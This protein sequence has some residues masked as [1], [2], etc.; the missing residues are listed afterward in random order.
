MTLMYFASIL[1]CPAC[2]KMLPL[3]PDTM[4]MMFIANGNPNAKKSGIT[5]N[6]VESQNSF[7]FLL[8]KTAH[9]Y[10]P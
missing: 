10:S 2:P 1:W 3:P 6:A 7:L 8:P 9:P 5:P 4:V